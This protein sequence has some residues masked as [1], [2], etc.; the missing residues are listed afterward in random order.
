M[1][2]EYIS[3]D[4]LSVRLRLPRRFLRQEVNAGRIPYLRVGGRL[5]FEAAAVGEALRRQ[6]EARAPGVQLGALHG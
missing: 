3:L 6:A 1:T 5:R 2:N 4:E